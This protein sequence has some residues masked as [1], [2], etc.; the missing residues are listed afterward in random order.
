MVPLLC[1]FPVGGMEHWIGSKDAQNI[2]QEVEQRDDEWTI[3]EGQEEEAAPPKK[4]KV[5]W[6][7]NASLT[8]ER[9]AKVACAIV[10]EDP[11]YLE[12][13]MWVAKIREVFGRVSDIE[14]VDAAG[15]PG[16]ALPQQGEKRK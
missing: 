4:R 3:Q 6:P 8:L 10:G 2:R 7:A 13:D 11:K 1:T 14:L 12:K 16:R 9:I 15:P 5:D